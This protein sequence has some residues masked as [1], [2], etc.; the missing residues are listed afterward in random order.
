MRVLVCGGREYSNAARVYWAL[1]AVHAKHGI[2]LI[3]EGGARGADMLGRAWAVARG[4]A[5]VTEEAEWKKYGAVAGSIR[6][7]AMLAKHNPEAV[8]AFTGNSGTADMVAKAR[9]AKVPVWEVPDPRP[10]IF[11]FGS[12]LAGRHGKGAAKTALDQYGAV[13]GQGIG[14]Q[15][16]SY[17]IPTKDA[18]LRPL[19][20]DQIAFYVGT[21][22]AFAAR[23]PGWDFYVTAIGC[24]LAGYKPEQIGPMF[25]DAPANCQLPDAFIPWKHKG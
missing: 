7:A 25:A 3:I 15:G 8:V 9:A 13:Y 10:R 16:N 24:G 4:I 23:C 12:N 22:K 21:F 19:S 11:V 1:D 6:N 2:T 5:F 18:L 17:A 14:M 20:L